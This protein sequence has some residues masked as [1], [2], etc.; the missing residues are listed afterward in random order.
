MYIY[1]YI[2]YKSNKVPHSN[3]NTLQIKVRKLFY[4]YIQIIQDLE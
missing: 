3:S 4:T 2:Y 1:I